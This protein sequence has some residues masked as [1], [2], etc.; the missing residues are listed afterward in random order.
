MK[1]I[2]DFK[3]YYDIG[4]HLD[5]DLYIRKTHD[6]NWEETV[7]KDKP[8]HRVQWR[9]MAIGFC[10]KIYPVLIRESVISEEVPIWE[11]FYT[12][13]EYEESGYPYSKQSVWWR[14][15]WTHDKDIKDLFLGDHSKYE[16]IFITHRVPIFVVDV[17]RWSKGNYR[18]NP[19]LKEF[20]FY[21]VMDSYTAYQ[22]VDMYLNG[23]LGATG[24][25]MLQVSDKDRLEA[26]GYDKHSFRM[27]KGRKKPRRK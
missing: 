10:G 18:L 13:K 6:Y 24:P 15:A 4:G 17:H 3:D 5:E 26:H 20:K 27:P 7:V 12:Y 1:I 22:E 11:V 2:S 23:V 8:G 16:D 25:T 19:N 9:H 21:K 14:R